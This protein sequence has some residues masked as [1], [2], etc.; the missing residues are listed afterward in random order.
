MT[1]TM[2]PQQLLA[3]ARTNIEEIS[4]DAAF[5][6]LG[7]Q[8]FIDVREA[9]EFAAGHIPGAINIPRGILEFHLGEYPGCAD[10]EAEFVIYCRSGARSALAAAQMKRLG[11]RKA[12]NMIGGY[13]AW[14]G[15][16]RPVET[17]LAR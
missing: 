17:P 10:K 13:L 6:R 4:T 16:G 15:E 7:K 14:S 1:M 12:V 9:N 11:Y 3:E 2:T 8:R 5:T